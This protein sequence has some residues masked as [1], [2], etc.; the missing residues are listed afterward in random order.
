MYS[1]L[2]W[3]GGAPSKALA[4]IMRLRPLETGWIN[5]RVCAVK[6][7]LVNVFLYR[8]D[9]ETVCFDAGFKRS[10][11]DCEI[12]GLG[13]DPQ[14]VSHVFLSHSDFDHAGGLDVFPRAQVY[15]SKDEEVMIAHKGARAR[16]GKVIY[17][18]PKIK[19]AYTLLGDGDTVLAGSIAVRAM[20]TPG[21]TPGSM[22]YMVDGSVLFS[23]D[24]LSL[25]DGKAYPN[26]LFLMDAEA[27]RLST[28]TLARL[29]DVELLV[30]AHWGY[31]RNY[32]EAMSAWTSNNLTEV[33]I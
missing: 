3:F 7:G 18:N 12:K 31:T 1:P 2:T 8:R 13:I 15:L 24:T 4:C 6:L 27:I 19:R 22:S 30:T 32:A 17:H 29:E 5:R 10:T 26:K 11:L 25:L 21:H 33:R 9:G 14:C 28:G 20:K 23:G 16:G